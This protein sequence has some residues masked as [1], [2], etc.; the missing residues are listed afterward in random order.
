MEKIIDIIRNSTKPEYR[1]FYARYIKTMIETADLFLE[2]KDLLEPEL[3]KEC[4]EN[5]ENLIK[6]L[7]EYK[8]YPVK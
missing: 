7:N 8:V 6:I 2:R 5:R 4:E 1:L 3:I